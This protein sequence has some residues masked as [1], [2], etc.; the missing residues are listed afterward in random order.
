MFLTKD[1]FIDGDYVTLVILLVILA[2]YIRYALKRRKIKSSKFVLGQYPL[3]GL[4]YVSINI[5]RWV[6]QEWVLDKEAFKKVFAGNS[7]KEIKKAKDIMKS[8]L[9][10][11]NQEGVRE[12]NGFR[13][14]AGKVKFKLSKRESKKRAYFTKSDYRR[15]ESLIHDYR[16]VRVQDRFDKMT[17]GAWNNAALREDLTYNIARSDGKKLAETD[18][19]ELEHLQILLETKNKFTSSVRRIN[20]SAPLEYQ[21]LQGLYQRKGIKNYNQDYVYEPNLDE[22]RDGKTQFHVPDHPE[23]SNQGVHI[24]AG[25]FYKGQGNFLTIGG[26]RSGKG[27]CLIIPQL[28][29]HG[30]YNGSIV[31]IDVKG[32]L[33]AITGKGLEDQSF[34]TVVL[35]PWNTQEKIG[36]KHGLKT[37]SFNPLDILDDDPDN[38]IDDCDMIAEMIVPVSQASN[39][40]YWEDRARQ[41]VSTYLLYIATMLP[42]EERTLSK[43]RSLFKQSKEENE[44][45]LGEILANS[46]LTVLK[47]NFRE[48]YADLES[49]DK[50]ALGIL[51]SVQRE[52]DI[53][54]SPAMERT[55]NSSTF[56]IKDITKENKRLFIVIPPERLV[57]HAKWLRLIVGCVINTVMR[58]KGR[59]VLLL[60]DE[61][62]SLGY[63]DVISKSMGLMPEYDLQLWAIVQDLSQLQEQYPQTWETFIANSAVTT[64]LGIRDNKTSEYLSKLLGKT[65]VNY[66]SDMTVLEELETGKNQSYERFELNRHTPDKI[67]SFDGIYSQIA[68]EEKVMMI[69]KIPYY[70]VARILENASDNPFFNKEADT[71][72]E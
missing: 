69:P 16:P 5:G 34:D 39:D 64:W 37:H 54:K 14:Y 12:H 61:F 41:W 43:L 59:K 36:A 1:I 31:A 15:Y 53:F 57:S 49:R 70:E 42:K 3:Y 68:G 60:M 33:T 30:S 27:T 66:K 22:I 47:E 29:E 26:A 35:D 11:L 40:K 48:I 21:L 67:R 46:E 56:D 25:Y 58:H 8:T 13:L 2:F 28:L 51:S 63:M 19:H 62:Y 71:K 44:D 6:H 9:E 65:L 18:L 52:I 23:I 72:L 17:M 32:T 10:K 7:S 45:M 50:V 24:G 38:L 55:L 4:N 20:S